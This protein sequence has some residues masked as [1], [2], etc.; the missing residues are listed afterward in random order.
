MA[1]NI[2]EYDSKENFKKIISKL[3]EF[4]KTSSV[5]LISIYEDND[6]NN[7]AVYET[8]IDGK[9]YILKHYYID[10]WERFDRETE[11]IKYFNSNQIVKTPELIFADKDLQFAV[12]SF[13]KG[14]NLNKAVLSSNHIELIVDCLKSLFSLNHQ[15][16][17]N[18]F[19]RY[20]GRACVMFSNYFENINTKFGLFLKYYDNLRE[21]NQI[22]LYCKKE[23]IVERFQKVYT[24]LKKH[25]SFDKSTENSKLTFNHCSFHLQNMIFDGSKLSSNLCFI[26]FEYCGWDSKLR[27]LADFLAYPKNKYLD[28]NLKSEFIKKCEQK[29]EL[30]PSDLKNLTL[31]TKIMSHE[32]TATFLNSITPQVLRRRRFANANLNEINYINNEL[33]RASENITK[34]E[35]ELL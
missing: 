15:D 17:Q 25:P 23:N 28:N 34:L 9:K 5:E 4:F 22:K 7:S 2:P 11:A 19:P 18:I 13:E 24:I 26:D 8:H 1:E 10:E 35:A 12:Y 3:T 31:I 27:V 6:I 30:S 14:V 20:A 32:Y 29:L 16:L 33:A 21:D